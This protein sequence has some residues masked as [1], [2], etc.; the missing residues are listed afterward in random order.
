MS[1]PHRLFKTMVEP[2]YR[3]NLLNDII[4]IALNNPTTLLKK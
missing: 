2:D 3:H 1:L 4:K